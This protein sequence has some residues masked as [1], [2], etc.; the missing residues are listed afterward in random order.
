MK[1]DMRSKPKVLFVV[2]DVYFSEPLGVMIL[3]AICKKAG[4][5]TRLGIVAREN[6]IE[7]LDD[8]RPDVIAYSTMTSDE[9]SF[10]HAN[11]IIQ[12]WS[13]NTG[14]PV[15]R[16]MGGPHPTYFPD[17]IHKLNLDAI[18]AGD[19]ERAIL[20]MLEAI[21]A[22]CSMEGIPN[23]S[24]PNVPMG[25]KEVI[26]DMNIIPWADRDIFYEAAPE[27]KKHG[28][29]SLL[30]MKGCPYKC[31]YCFNHAFNTMFK[32]PGVKLLR[33]R[34]VSD[35]LEEVK[36]LVENYPEVRFI[37]FADDVFVTP[38]QE[39]LDWLD[40]FTYRYPKEVGIPF[41]CLIRA[42]ALTEDVIK[43]LKKANCASVC[44]SV[45]AGSAHVRNKVLKRNM[46]DEILLDAFHGAR[47]N[48]INIWGTT[49]LGIPGTTIEDD[50]ESVQ[51]VQK[52]KIAYPAFTIFAP[53]PGTDLTEHSIELGLL[54]K[55]YD[56]NL[57]SLTGESV[58]TGYTSEEKKTQLN[59]YYLAPIF[60][61]LPGFL[62]KT[63]PFFARQFWLIPI[64]KHIG[65]LFTAYL[66]GTRIFPGARPKG[67]KAL[68]SA[69]KVHLSYLLDEQ[70][71]KHRRNIGLDIIQKNVEDYVSS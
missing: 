7:I 70:K 56:Y 24:T 69:L 12:A 43:K 10:A 15:K 60:C 4:Y 27:M 13:K 16:I 6:L 65:G 2:A 29:R 30:T 33:R 71:K 22:G 45:E 23:V 8:F 44:M 35:V 1:T 40:E 5:T 61:L 3:S 48:G 53:F 49:I 34:S 46:T 59:L 66:L 42:D 31:T 17:V 55:N 14:H 57:T 62:F 25:P 58:L 26:E 41:Y 32:G 21:Q 37:R 51:F 63:L 19:G 67:L 50:F 18:C 28:I 39:Q 11:D 36:S 68:V 54:D 20:N 9:N 47:N 64:Y 52:L 38:D